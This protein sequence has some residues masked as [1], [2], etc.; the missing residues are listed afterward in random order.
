MSAKKQKALSKIKTKVRRFHHS[1]RDFTQEMAEAKRKGQFVDLIDSSD[2]SVSPTVTEG[3]I[4]IS[5]VIPAIMEGR[6][7]FENRTWLIKPGDYALYGSADKKPFRKRFLEDHPEEDTPDFLEKVAK[8]EKKIVGVLHVHR[9]YKKGDADYPVDPHA[10]GDYTHSITF[11]PLPE[12]DYISGAY[13]KGQVTHMKLD[14]ATSRK[15]SRISASGGQG[16][17][18]WSRQSR[19]G[20]RRRP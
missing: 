10:N 17:R 20:R 8:V 4:L 18:R 15:L 7:R 6:K 11:S 9:A 5:S 3:L 19:K 16:T 2:E 12:S 14:P 1:L 13:K